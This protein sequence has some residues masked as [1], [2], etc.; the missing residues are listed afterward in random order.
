MRKAQLTLDPAFTVGPVPHRLFGSFVEHM[1]RCVYTGIFEP[2]HP[3]ADED[4]L[5]GDVLELTKQLAPTVVRYPGGN[6]V[7]GF[8]WEDSVGPRE[9]RPRRI[10]RAWRSVET[11]QFGLAEFDSW[12]RKVGTETMMAVNLGTRGLQDACNLLEY[13]NLD[14]GTKYADLRVAHGT[15]DPLGVKLWCL[16]NELDGPWQTGH[17]TAHEYGRLAAET[18]QAMRS[19]DPDIELVA[20]GSSSRSMPTFGAWEST[21][22]ELAYHTVDYVSC[23]AYYEDVD[24]DPASFLASAVDMDL[25]IDQVVATADAVRARGK[26][27][28]RIN[29]SFDEWNVWYQSR[30]HHAPGVQPW[31]VAPRVIED[32][33]S[34]TDAVVVGTL[35]NS[36]LRHADRVTIGAQAQLVNVIGLL[37]S[38]P[39][40]QAWKQTIAHPFEQVRH[41]ATGEVLRVATRSDK[42]ETAKFGDVDVVDASAT[43]ND[44][45]STVS[46][47]L[48]NRDLT[49]PAS[50]EVSLR[51]FDVSKVVTAK[52]LAATEGQDRHTTNA[53]G[54]HDQVGLRPLQ[55]VSVVDGLAT[56]VLPPLSWAVVQVARA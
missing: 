55:D 43:W 3:T 36:L 17:K 52:V 12:A 37:R 6:F 31:D 11:N 35:L 26:H 21:V 32:E 16:G 28:K 20:V 42:Q 30:P 15:K 19:I 40:G 9:E 24:D 34:I 5:R 25:F 48:A 56:V 7:S 4:G 1:G 50:V 22:L 23:H 54:S 38:E 18:G 10:D 41:L 46:L 33:Y 29:I 44:D 53:T 2:D 45:T 13:A 39:G 14:S 49:E 51:G 47:F 8:E 27:N